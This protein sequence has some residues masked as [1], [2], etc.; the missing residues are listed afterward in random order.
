MALLLFTPALARWAPM[1]G[2]SVVA[3]VLALVALLDALRSRGRPLE[4][5]V[6]PVAR[7]ASASGDRDV[8][9]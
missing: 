8:E 3:G 5:S 7:E 4:P 6:S 2:L 9:A 1:V